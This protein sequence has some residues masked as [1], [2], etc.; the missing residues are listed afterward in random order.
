[1]SSWVN[2]KNYTNLLHLITKNKKSLEKLYKQN[3]DS[4]GFLKYEDGKRLIIDFLK[5]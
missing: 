3:L 1:M 2:S 5:K 4:D